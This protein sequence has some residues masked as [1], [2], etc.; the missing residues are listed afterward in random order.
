MP[1]LSHERCFVGMLIPNAQL[2]KARHE[3]NLAEKLSAR[4]TPQVL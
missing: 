2:M 1:I 3:V 4:L